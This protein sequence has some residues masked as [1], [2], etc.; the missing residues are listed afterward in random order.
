MT[1]RQPAA[2][3]PRPKSQPNA[4]RGAGE[5]SPYII[6]LAA[7]GSGMLVATIYYAQPLIDPI[8]QD[9]GMSRQA[10]GLIVTAMQ[11]GYGLGLAFIVPLVDRYENRMLVTLSLMV[12]ALALASLAFAQDELTFL[13][14]ATIAGIA[15]VGAQV[16]LP[17]VAGMASL[18]RRGRVI[19]TI[20]TGLL[21]GIML[22]RP[23][24]SFIASF[25]GWRGVFLTASAA[26]FAAGILLRAFLPERRPASS[27]NYL[28]TLRSIL[29]AVAHYSVLRRRMGYQMIMFGLFTAFWTTVPLMLADHFGFDQ[30]KIA[31]FALAG[32]GGAL[33]APVAGRIAD[34]GWSR[35]ATMI[36]SV[37]AAIILPLTQIFITIGW[38]AALT[39]GTV[40]FDAC[41][42]TNQII[43]QRTIYALSD[44]ER[45]RINSAYM[46]SIFIA[47]A[48]TSALGPVLYEQFGWSAMA[49][50]GGALALLIAINELRAPAHN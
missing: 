40:L 9:I 47:G 6:W 34:C 19:G 24:S 12:T 33:A 31:L 44:A 8:S 49:Y 29:S 26:T 3:D 50:C 30:R 41:V 11:A 4:A 39:I 36:V 16:L 35:A 38:L 14:P 15:C 21:G 20:M 27:Q 1:T 5:P 46:T 13:L 25:I 10:A 23:T 45:G 7:I 28:A 17:M 43:G 22:A 48:F 2:Q 37:G 18:E 32:A 42:Q